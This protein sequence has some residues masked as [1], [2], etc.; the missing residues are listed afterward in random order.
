MRRPGRSQSALPLI[1]AVPQA[2]G[3]RSQAAT[4]VELGRQVATDGES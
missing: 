1:D 2:L 3:N 4:D